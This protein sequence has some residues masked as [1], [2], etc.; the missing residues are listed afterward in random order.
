MKV[1]CKKVH[2]RVLDIEIN[3]LRLIK[4]SEVKPKFLQRVLKYDQHFQQYHW[5]IFCGFCKN[6]LCVSELKFE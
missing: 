5:R 3:E 1:I 2:V 4:I 6:T